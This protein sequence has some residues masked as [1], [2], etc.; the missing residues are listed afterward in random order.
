MGTFVPNTKAQQQEM[1]K[2]IGFE[3]L[4]DLFAHIPD[5][6][7]LKGDLNLPD[8][9]SEMEV[10]R[11]MKKIADEIF[12]I[13]VIGSEIIMVDIRL[14]D[15]KRASRGSRV[16]ETSR[17]GKGIEHPLAGC[18][19]QEPLP[20]QCAVKIKP[21]VLIEPQIDRICHA[22][23]TDRPEGFSAVS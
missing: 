6:V 19:L 2:E 23:F 14:C 10:S 17:V 1:L 18:I 21:A 15:G 11:E 7:K 12:L 3:K 22:P 20:Q 8:G 5:D 16:T 4:D 13:T 9:M